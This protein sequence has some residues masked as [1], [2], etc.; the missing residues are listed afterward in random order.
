MLSCNHNSLFLVNLCPVVSVLIT[1]EDPT[2]SAE[3]F[4]FPFIRA[5]VAPCRTPDLI[6]SAASNIAFTGTLAAYLHTSQ[7]GQVSKVF[8]CT[9]Q[10][11]IFHLGSGQV[12][13]VISIGISA[14]TVPRPRIS[15]RQVRSNEELKVERDCTIRCRPFL[16]RPMCFRQPT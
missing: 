5:L 6:S 12:L 8:W 15:V 14:C 1:V 3:I 9:I 16:D 4:I 10:Y 2:R 11:H 13:I 7:V